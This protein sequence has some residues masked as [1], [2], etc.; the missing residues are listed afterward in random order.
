MYGDEPRCWSDTLRGWDRVRFVVNACTRIRFCD[1]HTGALDFDHKGAPGSQPEPLRPW[2]ELPWRQSRD[3]HVIFGHWS[4]LDVYSSSDVTGIDTGC[5][6]GR[7]LT[8]VC[9]SDEERRL[10]SVPCR[11]A[12]QGSRAGR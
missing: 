9:L 11:A 7:R 3:T 5:A 12:A 4:T 2:F 6:W 8:A 10:V 1:P